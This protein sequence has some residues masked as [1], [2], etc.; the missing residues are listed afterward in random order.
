MA[1]VGIFSG[2]F[3]PVHIGHIEFAIAAAREAQLEKVI[4]L[5]ERHPR[6]KAGVTSF[7][8]RVA[9]LKLATQNQPMFEVTELDDER[10]TVD[11]TLPKLQ[12]K[13]GRDLSLLI[14]S[15]VARTFVDRWPGLD[16]LLQQ[17]ELIIALRGTDSENQI[18]KVMSQI[19]AARFLCIASPKEQAASS[20]IRTGN[21]KTQLDP[22]VQTYIATKR[23]YPL[24]LGTN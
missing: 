7:A 12:L 5:P 11:T 15:D 3:D 10:F 17:M 19:G 6:G 23:L 18:K 22:N 4:L 20:K 16:K 24:A 9:M 14:G 2:T 13:Y 8:D 21:A 1:R